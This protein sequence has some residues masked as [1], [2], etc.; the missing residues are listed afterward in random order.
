MQDRHNIVADKLTGR[1][2]YAD[3]FRFLIAIQ[4]EPLPFLTAGFFNHEVPHLNNKAGFFRQ[5]DEIKRRY[6]TA[7]RRAPADQGLKATESIGLEGCDGL[8][9]K[10]KLLAFHRMAKSRV[11]FHDGDRMLTHIGCESLKAST[12][13][14]FGTIHREIGIA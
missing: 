5:R 10:F 4:V 6:E 7:F 11:E 13:F 8:I 3:P 1:D 9:E 14:G 12:A 2:I